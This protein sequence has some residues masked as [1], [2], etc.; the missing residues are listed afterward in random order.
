[1]M[2]SVLLL[3]ALLILLLLFPRLDMGEESAVFVPGETSGDAVGGGR[4]LDGNDATGRLALVAPK[5]L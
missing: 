2:V 4:G 3:L 1:M 5:F